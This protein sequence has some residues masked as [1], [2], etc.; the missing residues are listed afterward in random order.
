[1]FG[2]AS[3]YDLKEPLMEK[4]KSLV[5]YITAQEKGGT[6]ERKSHIKKS[7]QGE[8]SFIIGYIHFMYF[9]QFK[10]NICSLPT[11]R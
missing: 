3:L 6:R 4:K 11:I 9:I 8:G 5:A 7:Y 1:M 10:G 2:K